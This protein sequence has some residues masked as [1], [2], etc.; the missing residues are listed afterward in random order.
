MPTITLP[1]E[2]GE[3]INN[4]IA[5]YTHAWED[6][7]ITLE[8][9]DIVGFL[10]TPES[11]AVEN[12]ITFSCT[13]HAKRKANHPLKFSKEDKAKLRAIQTVEADSNA[14]VDAVAKP[15]GVTVK[16]ETK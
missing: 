8:P 10:M 1:P 5:A 3:Q 16:T 9:Y 12:E 14:P 6:F 4:I 7:A 15:Q 11:F 13:I 2:I